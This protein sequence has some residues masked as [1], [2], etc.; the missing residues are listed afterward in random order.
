MTS[1]PCEQCGAN[2]TWID[3]PDCDGM[4]HVPRTEGIGAGIYRDGCQTCRKLGLFHGSWPPDSFGNGGRLVCFECDELHDH[5]TLDTV[6][7][8]FP[9]WQRT[10]IP[11]VA[12]EPKPNELHGMDPRRAKAAKEANPD[13]IAW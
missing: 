11:P 7:N 4:G 9:E 10:Y 13:D 6:E 3:C 1:Y 5:E 8:P 12:P 2:R